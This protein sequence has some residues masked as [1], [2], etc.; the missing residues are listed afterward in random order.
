VSP[1]A[2]THLKVSNYQTHATAGVASS[3]TV[4]ALDK[5]ENTA[6]G[7]VGT[8]HFNSTDGQADCRAATRLS[9]RQGVKSVSR[10]SR[11]RVHKR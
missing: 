8:I 11:Q 10:R 5:Y 2:A 9:G 6:I 3:I 7:F 1:G 4:T